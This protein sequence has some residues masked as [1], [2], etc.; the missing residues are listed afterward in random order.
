MPFAPPRRADTALSPGGRV[1]SPA[2][3]EALF[4]ELQSLV[5][6]DA[7]RLF[8]GNRDFSWLI[9]S[10]FART[11]KTN[12]FGFNPSEV[13][14]PA[15]ATSRY[16]VDVLYGML[17]LKFGVLGSPSPQVLALS[18]AHPGMD[19]WFEWMK[20]MQQYPDTDVPAALAGTP[21]LDW[22][23][24]WRVGLWFACADAG[25]VDGAI[26]VW[27]ATTSGECQSTRTVRELLDRIAE[28]DWQQGAI[29]GLPMIFRPAAM[30]HMARATA[31]RALYVAQIDLRWPLEQV[32]RENEARLGHRLFLKIRV[33]DA[34][35]PQVRE[36]L[37]E[38]GIDQ[39]AMYPDLRPGEQ[40]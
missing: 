37:R 29:P 30:T 15:I 11:V 21:L 18:D 33:A 27:D 31:Q 2:T 40:I 5:S 20:N 32:F 13:P 12:A 6:Q 17:H 3:A 14:L 16:F 26:Y 34:L 9:D 38:D 28:H 7:L 24:D 39:A 23:T 35:K 25:N 22:S 10:K 8:R 19:P 4:E 36:L 1:W